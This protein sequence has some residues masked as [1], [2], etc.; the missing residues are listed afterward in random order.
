MPRIP[1]LTQR[2][3]VPESAHKSFDSIVA[4]RGRVGGPFSVL[5]NSPEICE[6]IAHTGAYLRFETSLPAP[7]RELSTLTAVR[8]WEC[9]SEWAAHIVLARKEG[10]SDATL[11]VVG[12]ML[13]SDSLSGAEK[14]VVDYVRELVRTH[15]VSQPVFDAANEALGTQGITDLTATAGYYCMISSVI[16]AMEVEPPEGGEAI[17][18]AAQ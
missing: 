11:D 18:A 6:R 12:R 1:Q 9:K 2:D 16:N 17:P 4:S 5:M 8:E 14:A 3:Q 15:H 7:L 13:P 10:V